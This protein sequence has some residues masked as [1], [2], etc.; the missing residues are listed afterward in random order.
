MLISLPL[1]LYRSRSLVTV[2][3]L[4]YRR[5]CAVTVVF[6]VLKQGR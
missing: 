6:R 4:M 1:A 5:F 2:S 3:R